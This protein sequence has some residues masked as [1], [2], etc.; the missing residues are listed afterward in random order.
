MSTVYGHT[1]EKEDEYLARSVP[2]APLLRR[3]NDL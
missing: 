2:L 3:R 1:W